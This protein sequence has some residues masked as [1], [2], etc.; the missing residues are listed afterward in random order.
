MF[1]GSRA[2]DA[3]KRFDD[4]SDSISNMPRHAASAD[5]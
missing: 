3:T 1:V 4:I 2:Y 5:D